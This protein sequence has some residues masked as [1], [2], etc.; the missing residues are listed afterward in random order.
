MRKESTILAYRDEGRRVLDSH[1]LRHIFITNLARAGIHPK[2][3]QDLARH[4]DIN[5][6]MSRYSHTVVADR[7]AALEKLPDLRTRPEGDRLRAT[8][9]DGKDADSMCTSLRGGRTSK[10]SALSPHGNALEPDADE[11]AEEPRRSGLEPLTFGSVDRCQDTV[12]DCH[13]DVYEP[14]EADHVD[15]PVDRASTPD[16]LAVVIAAWTDLPEHVR[17]TILTLVESVTQGGSDRR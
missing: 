15:Q 12:S 1:A 9:T 11:G 17:Q 7:A 16:D 10:E 2:Q 14:Q 6:T 5:L 4:S 8:G 3:A 13:T